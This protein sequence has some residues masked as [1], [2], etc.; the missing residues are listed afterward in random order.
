[1]NEDDSAASSQGAPSGERTLTFGAAAVAP[2]AAIPKTIGGYRVLRLIA[3]GGMGAVYE[4]EQEHPHRIVAL[5]VIRPGYT[6]P[7]MLR[8][9]EQEAQ[10]LGRLQHPG[11]A[12][13]Y[14][15]GCAT[16]ES[17]PQPY[18]AMELIHGETLLEYA[19]EHKLNTRQRLELVARICDAVQHAH[20]RGLVHRDLKPVNVLVD[21]TGQPKVLD[22]GVAR[23]TDSDSQVTRQTDI[24]QLIGTLP[25]MSPEQV[26]ADP[27]EVDPRTD[28]YALG[29]ILYELLAGKLPYSV[30]RKTL[31]DAVQVIREQEATRLSSV[32]RVYRGDIE[33]IVGKA[34]EKEKTRRY[35]SAAEL[36]SDIRHYLS[37]EPISAR[38]P[39]ATYQ[40]GKLVRR[41]R[42]LFTG[43][44]AVF[45]V[46]LG[47][48]VVSSLESVRARR[49]EQAALGAEAT[50]RSERDRAISAETSATRERDRA[51][52]AEHNATSER[53]RAVRAEAHAKR[54]RD[55]A[56]LERS[57]AD[58]EA[59]TA[60]AIN[61]FLQNDLLAQASAKNQQAGKADPDIKVRSVLDRAAARIAGHFPG[62]PKV[63]A[64]VEAT[65]GNSYRDLGLFTE[66][67]KHLS[68]A[69]E[70]D[71]A[72][73]GPDNPTT[74]K[75]SVDLGEAY[76]SA[77]KYAE[78]EFILGKAVDANTRTRGADD[79]ATLYAG[80]N[81]GSVY[82]AQGKNDKAEPLLINLLQREKRVL[83]AEHKT[84]LETELVLARVEFVRGKL[85]D[86]ERLLLD[87]LDGRRR[88]YGA[89][90]PDTTGI[91]NNL[92]VVYQRSG[93]YSDAEKLYVQVLDINKRVLGPDHTETLNVMNNLGVL[94]AVEGKYT[95][96]EPLY[97]YVLERWKK[98]LGPEHPR[99]LALMSNI[100]I[101]KQ[102]EGDYAAAEALARSVLD[103]RQRVLG[104]EHRET[105]ES[106]HILGRI[107]EAQARHT[108]AEPL[109]VKAF[110][111]TRRVLGAKHADTLL[112]EV[113]LAELRIDQA[114]YADAETLLREALELQKQ[115]R[116]DDY[117]RYWTENLLGD[118]LFRAGRLAEG[119]P[120]LLSG[121]EGMSRT[122][123]RVPALNRQKLVKAA[124]NIADFY[125]ASNQPAKA[126]E[127]RNR[128]PQ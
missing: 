95:Q 14:E 8:R 126:A 115:V 72:A 125:A 77:G 16:T 13:I 120:L 2:A 67:Q 30:D 24:G 81:L 44:A 4:A 34:L 57:R 38:P 5:K 103:I 49:A 62:N 119:E 113:D 9:F 122:A 36:A 47:G 94:Y 32:S 63:E 73:L 70:L 90:H 37:D 100:A 41:H 10:A 33:T 109:Y 18:F 48:V 40:L 88:L 105:L 25:Y 20:E 106:M 80:A 112:N 69:L 111:T 26:V 78:A 98:Q 1:M 64:A 56:V 51:I 54:D 123:A 118:T 101:L 21:D 107:Y 79:E 110:E 42:A 19:A 22:F 117:Q 45:V 50:T 99:T 58:S 121:Y 91:M 27:S 102:G 92:A 35:T 97:Q 76:R 17:G 61:D 28:V 6:S 59:N 96:A 85:A 86:A 43:I 116:P 66:A 83:G 23:L 11:I 15:A 104:P 89:E 29:I 82:V 46:L 53:D 93:K 84:T 65:I 7:E 127:W 128:L 124:A 114:R 71:Q 75:V 87:V 60:K 74:L 108:D 12:R 55:M 52:A 39:S 68:R 31:P 3:Q